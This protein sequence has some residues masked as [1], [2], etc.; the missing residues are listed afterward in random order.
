MA[1]VF[2]ISVCQIR[3]NQPIKQ[4][5]P[6][7]QSL[8]KA[9]RSDAIGERNDIGRL[10][11]RWRTAGNCQQHLCRLKSILIPNSDPFMET[12]WEL[13]K[14][15]HTRRDIKHAQQL[16]CTSWWP[17]HHWV[18]LRRAFHR[19]FQSADC[20]VKCRWVCGFYAV[21]FIFAVNLRGEWG[22]HFPVFIFKWF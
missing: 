20:D 16:L 7:L 6:W 18:I 22:R 13:R 17:D 2:V 19:C 3:Q 14:L 8:I 4:P 12:C 10:I 9:T 1:N 11:W 21:L 15:P 5:L